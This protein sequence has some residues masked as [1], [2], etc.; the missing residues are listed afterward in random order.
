MLKLSRLSKQLFAFDLRDVCL[1]LFG[2]VAAT[3]LYAAVLLIPIAPEIGLAVRYNPV[4]AL[5]VVCATAYPIYRSQNQFG[6]FASLCVTLVLFALPLTGL[7]N[8][9]FSDPAALGGL[10]PLSDGAAYYHDAQLVLA[11]GQLG[12]VSAGRP[13]F[14]GM[15]VTL[16]G[17]TGQ[18]LQATLA[19]LVMVNA[20][21]CFL[22]ARE[23]QR[24]HGAIAGVVVLAVLFLF[25]TRFSGT[26]WTENLGLALG[27]VSFALLW[28]G[29]RVQSVNLILLG[30]LLL[31][32]ALNARAGAMLIL[33]VLVAWGSWF[34]RGSTKFSLRFLVLATGAVL[35]GF[36]INFFVLL[37]LGQSDAV[38]FSNFSYVLY[39][40]ALG[41]KS[42]MQ[43]MTDHP[44]LKNLELNERSQEIYQLAF[45][46]IRSNPTNLFRGALRAWSEYL[47][48]LAN[49]NVLSFVR[50]G[51]IRRRFLSHLVPLVTYVLYALY[52]LS[53]LGI[54]K[55][56]F[57]RRNPVYS[58]LLAACVGIFISVPF[59]PPVDAQGMRVY[60]ATIP[61]SAAL[62][63]VGCSFLITR[64]NWNPGLKIPNQSI[65]LR[66]LPA[67]SIF[68]LLLSS[69]GPVTTKALNPVTQLKTIACQEN[70]EAVYVQANSGSSINLLP[71]ESIPRSRLPNLRISDF[72]NGMRSKF[73]NVRQVE[74]QQFSQVR[75]NHTIISALNLANRQQD[76]L[77]VN[78]SAIAQPLQQAAIVG[79]CGV[80]ENGLIYAKSIH[81]N[82]E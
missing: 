6:A 35:S 19:I 81:Q 54:L 21:A 27:T 64:M 11:G 63:A 78:T 16:L 17:L 26:T 20:I 39:G 72:R 66:I 29:V 9:G 24:S 12:A 51:I 10:L 31:T 48:P 62:P 36:A 8:S 38:A 45:E 13:L 23:V 79:V 61:V 57:Q 71:N 77:I 43:V 47:N 44:E 7:W 22:F 5:I 67:F 37:A 69:L 50:V 82:S 65:R 14:P 60:A 80:R 34:F 49:Y 4:F 28:R 56:Y 55:C 70:E 68:L 53:L 40:L 25:Y 3:F 2:A 42:W 59:A 75:P 58:L 32:L 18:N 73:K 74:F 33:P 52:A 15:L 41:G 30:I 46:A 76:W 1:L